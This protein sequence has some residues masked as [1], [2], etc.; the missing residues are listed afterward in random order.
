MNEARSI[1]WPP[2]ALAVLLLTALGVWFLG[3]GG[4]DTSLRDGDRDGRVVDTDAEHEEARG[5]RREN[6]GEGLYDREAPEVEEDAAA[7]AAVTGLVID[8]LTGDP[9]AAARVRAYPAAGGAGVSVRSGEAGRFRLPLAPGAWRLTADA[10]DRAA[11]PEDVEE[12][13]LGEERDLGVLVLLPACA[14]RG[15][16]VDARAKPV[17]GAQVALHGAQD[18]MR[19]GGIDMMAFF[20]MALRPPP[21]ERTTTSDADGNFRFSGV[22]NGQYAVTAMAEGTSREVSGSLFLDSRA[23]DV[24]LE[25]VL[26][27]AAELKGECVDEAGAPVAGVRI[28]AIPQTDGLPG[29]GETRVTESGA[30][31]TFAIPGGLALEH[32]IIAEAE[33]YGPS[34]GKCEPGRTAR[35]VMKRGVPLRGRI[36]DFD[37]G[38]GLAG[39]KVVVFCNRDPGLSETVSD[40]NGNFEFAAVHATAPLQVIP[41]KEGWYYRAPDERGARNFGMMGSFRIDKSE[42][43]RT[44]IVQDIP[45]TRGGSVTGRVFDQATGEPI[46]G[47]KV[48]GV[49]TGGDAFFAQGGGMASPVTTDEAGNFRIDDLPPGPI[50]LVAT[51]PDFALA[52]KDLQRLLR[53]AGREDEGRTTIV[54]AGSVVSGRDIG[55]SRAISISGAVRDDEGTPLHF[56]EVGVESGGRDV[57]KLLFANQMPRVFSD[58]AGRFTL[59]GVSPDEPLLTL[60]ATHPGHPG[61]GRLE[62]GIEA[63][64]IEPAEIVIVVPRGARLRGRLLDSGGTPAA[65][66]TIELRS[67]A[68][69]SRARTPFDGNRR[70]RK[71]RT[72]A[73]GRFAFGAVPAGGAD[74]N[75]AG[76]ASGI[77]REED[78]KLTLAP[79]EDREVELRL[80]GVAKIEGWVLDDQGQPLSAV[81]VA[82]TTGG[83]GGGHGTTD[84][85]GRFEIENLVRGA[86]Y[87][88]EVNLRRV[89]RGA[90]KLPAPV[91]ATAGGAA[92][93]ISMV[94]GP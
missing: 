6:A 89:K 87:A 9:I 90:W 51:H 72:D 44:E 78:R 20:R 22:P 53:D 66:Q 32:T 39:A 5:A 70:R 10:G 38:E 58:E 67:E 83:R 21:P 46:P 94:P 2:I 69:A 55:L 64:R 48:R 85:T 84:D 12:L 35:I 82:T 34:G 11:P 3:R 18:L 76:D 91:E 59:R 17:A 1:P 14:I 50:G 41:K 40:A 30:D 75:L 45:M 63:G 4:E 28:V 25:F 56:A 33:G 52:A 29:P 23:G 47:A 42:A 81:V 61:G 8:G 71:T 88:L 86:T 37:T 54:I 92:V 16:V 49:S 93:R 15:R 43:P 62:V 77:L 7:D 68:P 74:L 79:G 80:V 27:A 24:V 60:L 65:G 73:E 31:G 19:G 57:L 36:Y 26:N 13:A